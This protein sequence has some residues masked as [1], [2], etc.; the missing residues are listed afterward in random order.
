MTA[1]TQPVL[2]RQFVMQSPVIRRYTSLFMHLVVGFVLLVPLNNSFEL[3]ALMQRQL[4]TSSEVLTPLYIK[5][6]K[7]LFLVLSLGLALLTTIQRPS[8][9]RIWLSRPFFSRTYS[10]CWS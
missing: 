8:C 10:W 1:Q 2:E 9:A 6:I 5:A 4:R 7:D 3:V